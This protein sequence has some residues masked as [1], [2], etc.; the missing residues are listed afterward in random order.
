[1]VPRAALPRLVLLYHPR[2]QSLVVSILLGGQ[3][4]VRSERGNAH[5]ASWGRASR[6]GGRSPWPAALPPRPK[7]APGA[8]HDHAAPASPACAGDAGAHGPPERQPAAGRERRAR[9]LAL[10]TLPMV[11]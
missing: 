1:V 4:R 5:I 7:H 10:L 3:R 2:A 8:G 9:R 11:S 6:R